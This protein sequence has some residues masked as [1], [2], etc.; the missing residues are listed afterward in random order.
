MK[1]VLKD[2]N[3]S[4]VFKYFEEISQI[5]R[6]SGNEK[7]ISN[8]LYKFAKDLGLEVIQDEHLNILIRKPA[9][10]GYENC[11]GVILQGHMDMV[12]EKNKDSDH[13]FEKDP[14]DLRIIDDMIYANGTTLG[15]DNGIAVAMGLAVLASNDLAHPSLEVLITSNEEAGM[16]GANGLDGGILKGK[17]I[18]NLDSEE[19]GY[20]LVSCAGGNRAYVTLPLTYKSVDENKQALLVEVKGLLGGH[21]GMDIVN[22]I[23]SF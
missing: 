16:T 10:E 4:L 11:P 19:E 17:Y 20:L 12:C 13:D 2:L 22:Y 15:A 9:T 3:P 14:I 1:N 7:E 18:I 6:G 8:F 21:S 5:P 23:F